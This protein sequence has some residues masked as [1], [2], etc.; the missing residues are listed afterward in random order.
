ML[1]CKYVCGAREASF[2][3][4]TA[5]APGSTSVLYM[6]ECVCLCYISLIHSLY[7][8]VSLYIYVHVSCCLYIQ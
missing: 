2:T 1:V 6:C 7:L 8:S 5:A 4:V 3:L